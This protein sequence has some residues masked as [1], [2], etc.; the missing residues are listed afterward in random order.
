MDVEGASV[1]LV[2]LHS[3]REQLKAPMTKLSGL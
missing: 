1:V 2:E 3:G